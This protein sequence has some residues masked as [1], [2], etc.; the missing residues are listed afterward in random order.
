MTRRVAL[1]A[2]VVVLLVVA[3]GV[4]DQ[5][6]VLLDLTAERS[7]TLSA[8][9]RDVVA[10][11]DGRV[12][13]TA[14]IGRDEVGRVEAVALLDRYR[15]LDDDIRARVLDPAEASGERS[16]LGVDPSLGN[17]AVRVGERV[18]IAAAVT[19]Q[20]VT[21]AIAR[22]LRGEPAV[23]CV[24]SGH[25]ETG[26]DAEVLV[27]GGFDVRDL[28]LLQ[29]PSVPEECE[30]VVVASPTEP[31]GRAGSALRSW[32]GDDRSLLVL[33]DPVSPVDL[34]PLVSSFGLG[35]R[36]GV[37]LEGEAASVIDDDR[38]API[39]R[40]F[41][42]AN[43]IVRNLAPLYLPGVQEVVVDESAEDEGLTLS[44]LADTSD[45]SY[46]ETEP[47]QASFDARA[48]V[49]G[50]ITVA[51]AADRSRLEGEEVRRSR[52]VVV[53]DA[54]LATP[55]FTDVGAN[56]RFLLQAVGWLAQDEAVI[57]LSANVP[58]DRPL[59][60]TDARIAYAR[61]LTVVLVPA[62]LLLGGAAV[63]VLR[64]GR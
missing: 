10:A 33:A 47:L 45:A 14:F 13:I 29:A 20:D 24:T 22:A 9:T 49:P 54:D 18:E 51:A 25:G 8:V 41:P 21:S 34:T 50:P 63:W 62:L 48:D 17:V 40:R 15:R 64:R 30:V 12:E 44:R 3:V 31:L 59:R 52:V 5:N 19:E 53:G 23:V 4:A 6:R 61:L 57:P 32:V 37:V 36:R 16:R 1:A 7:L 27:T 39:V 38:A 35:L 55:A 42:T 60:L 2:V 43:P 56:A 11:T 28:D 26:V 46:L 58:L